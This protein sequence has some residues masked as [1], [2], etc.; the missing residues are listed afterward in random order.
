MR[1]AITG[2]TGLVGGALL[3][4]LRS[5]GHEVSGGGRA[6]ADLLDAEAVRRA[7]G[8]AEVIVHCAAEA[9][10]D[11]AEREPSVAWRSNVDATRTLA[12]H[13]RETGAHLVHVSTDYVFDGSKGACTVDEPLSPLGVYGATKAAAEL[14][15]RALVPAGR[16][17][18]ARTAVVYGWPPRPVRKNFGS[19]L[20][21]ELAAGRPARVFSDQTITPTHVA[22]LTEMAVELVERRLAGTWHLAG[23]EVVSRLEFGQR[24][25]A[26]FGFSPSLLE[27]TRMADAKQ[28]GPRPLRGGLDVSKTTAALSAKPLALDASL[29]LLHAAFRPQEM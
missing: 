28:A 6:W 22:N 7:V 24:L 4:A 18:I 1:V 17:A 11:A 25:C 9:D 13:A 8:D 23:A 27:A 3:Q 20:L 21:S 10:V 12:L 26:R 19:W 2:A 14:A 16:W 29:E 15:V 5:R